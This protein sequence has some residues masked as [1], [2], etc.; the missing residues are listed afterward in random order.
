MSNDNNNTKLR[1]PEEFK[2][3]REKYK[4]KANDNAMD[5]VRLDK[6]I[7]ELEAEQKKNNKEALPVNNDN[8]KPKPRTPEE[9]KA[10]LEKH[11]RD[12]NTRN[13]RQ[14]RRTDNTPSWAATQAARE[15][16][17]SAEGATVLA[18]KRKEPG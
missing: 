14:K 3:N 2:A 5:F 12:I 7:A 18:F 9:F 15:K 11:R 8:D 1:T 10:N 13:T 16:I 4:Q 17:P 6:K